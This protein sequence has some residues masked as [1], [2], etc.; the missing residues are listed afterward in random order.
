LDRKILNM[1][2]QT[3]WLED[4]GFTLLNSS[5]FTY[6]NN[7]GVRKRYEPRTRSCAERF[8]MKKSCRHRCLVIGGLQTFSL[9]TTQFLC[10]RT[11]RAEYTTKQSSASRMA[12]A[13]IVVNFLLLFWRYFKPAQRN[14]LEVPELAHILGF[15][16]HRK[17]D[18]HDT[19]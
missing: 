9:Q 7:A 14:V 17:Y 16:V 19:I 6:A 13:I 11:E 15:L 10:T 12:I 8:T 1:F 4:N 5:E 3:G 18:N 2:R